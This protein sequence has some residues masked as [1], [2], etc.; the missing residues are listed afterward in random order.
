MNRF[1]QLKEVNGGYSPIGREARTPI[2]LKKRRDYSP[3]LT[4]ETFLGAIPNVQGKGLNR[5]QKRK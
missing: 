3:L 1:N 5:V 4:E 2:G